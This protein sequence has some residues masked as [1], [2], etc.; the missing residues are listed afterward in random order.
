MLVRYV[1][2]LTG[3]PEKADDTGT[4]RVRVFSILALKYHDQGTQPTP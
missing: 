2:A 1:S 3:V 4:S